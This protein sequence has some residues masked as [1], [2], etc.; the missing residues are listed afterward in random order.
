MEVDKYICVN[1]LWG[2][3][4]SRTMYPALDNIYFITCITGIDFVKV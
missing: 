2:K 4:I 1:V 3:V